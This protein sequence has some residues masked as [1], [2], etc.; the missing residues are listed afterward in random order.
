M[1]SVSACAPTVFSESEGNGTSN[2]CPA[3]WK[4]SISQQGPPENMHEPPKTHKST[5]CP[6]QVWSP[7][8]PENTRFRHGP[9]CPEDTGAVSWAPAKELCTLHPPFAFPGAARGSLVH[10]RRLGAGGQAE[11]IS[12][13]SRIS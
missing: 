6:R 10:R 7:S 11:H 4:N 1:E 5:Q 9:K 8:S 12:L 3:H 13:L 2:C